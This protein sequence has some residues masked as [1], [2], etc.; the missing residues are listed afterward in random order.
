MIRTLNKPLNWLKALLNEIFQK[1]KNEYCLICL[2][3]LFDVIFTIGGIDLNGN[4]P[5]E[6]FERYELVNQ[7]VLC[8]YH[9]S[10][11][12]VI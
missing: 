8:E 4:D 6:L 12:L 10:F 2:N 9:Q 11:L 7:E 1:V 3:D 5:K